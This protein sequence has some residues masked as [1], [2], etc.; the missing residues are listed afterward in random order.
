MVRCLRWLAGVLLAV[1]ITPAASLASV[2][3]DTLPERHPSLVAFAPVGFAPPGGS[4]ATQAEL[5]L[6][7]TSVTLREP[8]ALGVIV[9]AV[10]A[11]VAFRLVRPRRAARRGV[12]R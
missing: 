10:A 4:T 1:A 12:S 5:E 9:I 6:G 11:V 8:G 2:S 3:V 7:R